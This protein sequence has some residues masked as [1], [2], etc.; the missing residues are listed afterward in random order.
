MERDSHMPIRLLKQAGW[1]EAG[2]KGAHVHF[3]RFGGNGRITRAS[4]E[5]GRQDWD[6]RDHIQASRLA[7]AEGGMRYVALI[8]C[9]NEPGF[10]IGFPDFPGCVS[11][12]GTVEEAIRRGREALAFHIESMAEDG[13]D[14][15]RPRARSEIEADP[16]MA[17]WCEGAC[18]VDIDIADRPPTVAAASDPLVRG[19]GEIFGRRLARFVESSVVSDLPDGDWSGVKAV[20]LLE[21]PHTTEVERGRPLAGDSGEK[22]TEHLGENIPDMEGISGAFGDLV[23]AGDPR[24]SRVGIMNASRLPL[25]VDPYPE[26]GAYRRADVPAW[27]EFAEC[28]PYIKRTKRPVTERN[29]AALFMERA[30]IRDLQ[31]RLGGIPVG[32]DLLLV[33]CGAFAQGIFERTQVRGGIRIAYAP[34]PSP[35]MGRR[36]EDYADYMRDVYDSIAHAIR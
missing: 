19:V 3:R 31:E 1:Y 12:G 10:G 32:N 2:R 5:E 34:H 28:L 33:C 30:I 18:I 8:H 35:I 29:E 23:A 24:V 15:P 4:P 9:D 11:D 17:E 20:L 22:V 16:D 26:N 6:A 14:I 36:W 7:V 13:E 27:S 25:Q 21:S